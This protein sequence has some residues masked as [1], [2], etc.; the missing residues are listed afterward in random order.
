MKRKTLAKL[1]LV[2]ALTIGYISLPTISSTQAAIFRELRS[3]SV[4]YES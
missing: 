1:L 3:S 4:N 2:L